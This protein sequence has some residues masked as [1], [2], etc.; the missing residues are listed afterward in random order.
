M[1]TRHALPSQITNVVSTIS[2]AQKPA[3]VKMSYPFFGILIHGFELTGF[4]ALG[5]SN[6]MEHI[7][8]GLSANST[9]AQAS[10]VYK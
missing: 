4:L 7:F 5:P 10:N 3:L 6:R 9:P 8:K 1:S 2:S